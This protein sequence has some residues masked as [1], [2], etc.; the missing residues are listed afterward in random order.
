MAEN[1]YKKI[2]VYFR[3]HDKAYLF[4]RIIYRYLPL[5]IYAV[6]PVLLINNFIVIIK[7]GSPENFIRTLTVP[8]V[9]FLSVSILRV[10]INK[11]RPYE[12]MNIDPLIK[13]DTIGKSFPSRHSA[14]IFTIAMASFG[15]SVWVGIAL[16]VIGIIMCI[17]RVIAGVHYISDVI[18]GAVY[19][20]ILGLIGLII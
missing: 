7:G 1:T 11:P 12:A 14:S 6:Y 5:L 2:E 9:T 18:A 10:I 4:L 8:A 15:F 20:I 3:T 17:S 16:I 13:K 19:S